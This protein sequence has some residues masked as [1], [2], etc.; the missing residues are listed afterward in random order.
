MAQ[1]DSGCASGELRF[2]A[3]SF[4]FP[5]FLNVRVWIEARNQTLKQMRAIR[6]W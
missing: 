5:R 2:P 1:D 4:L 3:V 6:S